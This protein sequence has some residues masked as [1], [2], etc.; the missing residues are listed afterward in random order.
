[1]ISL[2]VHAQRALLACALTAALASCGKLESDAAKAPE[3]SIANAMPA[4]MP[5]AMPV[6]AQAEY[7]KADADEKPMAKERKK[8][9]PAKTMRAVGGKGHGSGRG[10][11]GSGHAVAGLMSAGPGSGM[12]AEEASVEGGEGVPAEPAALRSWFPETF[13]W[14]P[15][16]IT[17]ASGKGS[18]DVPVP[19]RLTTWR[20][21][22]LAHSQ[23][24]AQSGALTSFTSNL[25]LSV[26]VVL[27]PF[28]VAGDRV[29]LPIQLVNSTDKSITQTLT[30]KAE[31]ASLTG[32]PGSIS[33][34]PLGTRAAVAW[35]EA[36]SPGDVVVEARVE[37]D[38]VRRTVEVHSAGQPQRAE[39]SGTL[40]AKRTFKLTLTGPGGSGADS[41]ALPPVGPL[42]GSSLASVQVFPGALAILRAELAAAPDRGSRDDDGYLAALAGRAGALSGKLGAPVP[43]EQLLRLQRIAAQRAA[44]YAL[45]P[46]L[47]T[48][49]ALAPGACT[50]DTETLLGRTGEHLAAFAARAQRPDGTFA[51]GDG[52][53]LPRLLVATADGVRTIRA[54]VRAAPTGA[55]SITAEAARDSARR[56]IATT[57]R[58]RGAFER[59]AGRIDD[60]YTAAVVAASGA[61][62]GDV[63]AELRKKVIAALV[64]QGD[65]A[66]ALPVPELA[67][68]A[69]GSRPN[70][71]EATAF[72]ILALKDDPDATKLLPDLG[73]RV[74]ASY[75]PYAGFGDGRTNLIALD[76]VSLLFADPLPQQV[77]VSLT[78]NGKARG[79]DSLSGPRL[80]EV[81]TL[82]A[83]IADAGKEIEVTVEAD[84]PV[85]GL[86]YV[87]A[88]DFATPWP[89][90]PPDA[91]LNLDVILPK[92]TA[93]QP[94]D[95]GLRAVA[96]GGA[97]LRITQGLPAGV[98]VVKTS[99][100]ALRDAGTISSFEIKEGTLTVDAPAR[101]QGELFDVKVKVVPTL[102]GTLHARETSVAL[103]GDAGS[104]VYFPPA[105]WTVA[106]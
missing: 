51:G 67:F 85:P 73:A 100:E 65:G 76:A 88:V 77:V 27:P 25:P 41:A 57:L 31:G 11:Y 19:D 63:L 21:L 37:Q 49:M 18:V 53:P 7:D 78:V 48:A 32:A 62:D 98:D 44:R 36:K 64:E 95:M 35:L 52:W 54:C 66:R 15:R 6:E 20:I 3:S 56:E 97:A 102:A 59:N 83:D 106:R 14:A 92:M 24:G 94:A 9:A 28:L 90:P 12:D 75:R 22:A 105:V 84:P 69:D 4:D 10:G 89:A 103:A 104:A 93:G 70:E 50:H 99:L 29:A 91:G 23:K 60:A 58:A 96:P 80:H 101:N 39:K 55:D 40:A 30:T 33:V 17:D 86:S 68:R 2:I 13:L 16:V 61:V 81:M 74:L 46:N 26:D 1:M 82:D 42:P 43:S 71:T 72:A 79:S 38:A 47:D 45:A 5:A 34:D 8:M 87:F